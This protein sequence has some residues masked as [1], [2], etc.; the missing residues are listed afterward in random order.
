MAVPRERGGARGR[1]MCC[2]SSGEVAA[3]RRRGGSCG[4]RAGRARL[5][6]PTERRDMA[7]EGAAEGALPYL[8]S[9]GKRGEEGLITRV[10]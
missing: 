3:Q 4:G 9:P 1:V 8:F 6:P 5:S 10:Y 7:A 2:C